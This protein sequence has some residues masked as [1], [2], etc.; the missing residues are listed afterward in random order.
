MHVCMYVKC[1]DRLE[2]SLCFV[3][4]D[5]LIG[6]FNWVL[7]LDDDDGRSWEGSVSAGMTLFLY[8]R[9]I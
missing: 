8:G 2:M 7:R 4:L 6:W 3:G 9:V 5:C 1:V